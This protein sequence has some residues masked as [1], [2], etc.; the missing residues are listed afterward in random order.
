MQDALFMTKFTDTITIVHILDKLTA[1]AHM[2][3]PILQHPAVTIIYNST[4]SEISG[5]ITH[6]T[7]VT[8]KNQLTQQEETLPTA[9]VFLAIGSK[10][11]TDFLKNTIELD[12]AGHIKTFGTVSTSS[13]NIFACGDAID[14]RYRQAI[15]ASGSGCMAAIDAQHYLE[16]L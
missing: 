5:N 4:I 16:Q 9:A 8:I 12:T 14:Y 3:Q 13:K 2:Q 6:V 1:S 7:H 11:N 15:T 10:P